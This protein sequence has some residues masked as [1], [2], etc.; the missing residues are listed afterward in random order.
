MISVWH[1]D[2]DLDDGGGDEEPGAAGGEVGHHRV[3]LGVR[4]L[5]VDQT[6]RGL[7]QRETQRAVALLGGSH[8]GGLALL[9]QGTD[10]VGLAALRDRPAQAFDHLF[11]AAGGDQRGLDRAAAGGFLVEHREVHVAVW[12]R[13]RLRGIGVAVITRMSG[14]WPLAA[15]S[16]ALAHAETVLLVD[17]GEAQVAEGD[18]LLEERVGADDDRGLAFGQRGELG[19]ALG[20]P[21]AAGKDGARPTPA[22][23]ASG[24]SEAACWRARISV[25][26]IIAAWPRPR[27]R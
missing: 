6:D 7:A 12:A 8:V 23:A 1:V 20:A 5:A 4:H 10:P 25:G 2:A 22:A 13:V 14:A 17:D 26:A 27:R 24:P 15:S 9:D 11:G 21:V 3:T 19:P 16:I 18:R